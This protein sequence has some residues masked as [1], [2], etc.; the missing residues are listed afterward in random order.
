VVDRAFSEAGRAVPVT[1]WTFRLGWLLL[2]PN[3]KD[4]S[5]GPEA[6]AAFSRPGW[7]KVGI[8]YRL[9]AERGGT[10]LRTETR[11]K[12]TGGRARAAFWLSWALIRVGSGLIR[13][14]ILATIAR[15][16]ERT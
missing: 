5:G 9:I 3:I 16:A 8:D 2:R 13:R 7:V 14:E 11:C 4:L 15:R 6:F 10:R 1:R 12:A